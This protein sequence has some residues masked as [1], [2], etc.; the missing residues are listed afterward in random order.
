MSVSEFERAAESREHRDERI[1][2]AA[3]FRWTA[4]FDMH[5]GIANHF[6]YVTSDNPCRFLVNPYGV[7][8]SR[9]RG[10]DLIT[11]DASDR[12]ELERDEVDPT[13]WSIHGAIHRAVPGARCIMHVHSHYATALSSL[14]DKSLPPI[15]QTSARFFE[16]VAIDNHFDGM[17][18]GGEAERL[19]T[20]L[21]GKS[22][23]M[24]GNHG[25]MAIG[26]TIGHTFDLMYF[27]ERACKNFITALSSGR[28]LHVIP[29]DV[30]RKTTAQWESYDAA[31]A[32]E[33]HLAALKAILDDEEPGYRD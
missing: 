15:D 16:R 31:G 24:M 18:L 5:E 6:S 2:L 1:D 19:A 21:D 32:G 20:V 12:G 3:A 8:F 9:I 33:K 4:R 17:G 14:R 30:A 29:D 11:V 22:I 25:F 13:A 27:F 7:H 23:V 28:E 26:E 10:S